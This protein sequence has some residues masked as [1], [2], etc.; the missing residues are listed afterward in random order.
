MLSQ[1]PRTV[2]AETGRQGRLA[3]GVGPSMPVKGPGRIRWSSS[4]LPHLFFYLPPAITDGDKWGK[5]SS[6]TSTT[7]SP[8]AGA[9]S[10]TPQRPTQ[11]PPGH[12]QPPTSPLLLGAVVSLPGAS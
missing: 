12:G 11:A 4:K 1:T 6:E 7:Q 9:P 3:F 2:P 10:R 8:D 5:L